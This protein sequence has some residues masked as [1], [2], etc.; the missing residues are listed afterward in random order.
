M[1]RPEITVVDCTIRDGG[2]MNNSKFE[3]ETVRAV[4]KAICDSGVHVV[5]LGYRNSKAMLSTDEY[6]P[7]RFCDE[8]ALRRVTDGIETDTKIAVMMDAHKSDAD[9]LVPADES[10]VDMIRVATYVK[11]VDKAIA[12]ANNATSKGYGTAINIMAISHALDRELDEALDQINGETN[13]DACYIVDSF[14]ALYSEDIDYY[15]DKYRSHLEN[16][17]VGIHCHNQQ[18]LGFAN[19]IEAIIKDVNYLDGTLLGIGRAAGNCPLELLLGFLKNPRFDIRPILD[20]I[21]S[22][23][24]PLRENLEWGYHLPYMLSGV[25]NVHP[26]ASIKFMED[27]ASDPAARNYRSF[28]DQLLEAAR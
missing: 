8:E 16:I 28:H 20:V 14:G 27:T 5:E 21:G 17:E 12:L 23:I 6:G 18:Q 22:H 19:T 3:D 24:M 10:V 15:V 7:W 26:E 13:I 1:F 2:L 9:D 25:M 4:Y 11:D